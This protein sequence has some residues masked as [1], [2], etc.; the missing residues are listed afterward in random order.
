MNPQPK[1]KRIICKPYLDWL[2]TQRCVK[3]NDTATEDRTVDPCHQNLGYGFMAG[4]GHDIFALP[5]RSDKHKEEHRGHK[6]F[7]RGYDIPMLIMEHLTRYA[8]DRKR[9]G[10]WNGMDFKL[11]VMDL[12]VKAWGGE[13]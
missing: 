8:A 5:L 4:K 13:R 10:F 1:Q 12:I 6:T 7:W 11:A 2:K 3:T 9:K